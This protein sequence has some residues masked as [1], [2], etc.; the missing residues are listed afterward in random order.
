MGFLDTI[1]GAA[2]YIKDKVV[3]AIKPQHDDDNTP[4][5][6]PDTSRYL[7]VSVP[8]VPIENALLRKMLGRDYMRVLGPGQTRNVG[9]NMMKAAADSMGANNKERRRLR[10][11][12]KRRAAELRA[13]AELNPSVRDSLSGASA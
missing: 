3:N 4:P 5:P 7:H 8:L 2:K 10:T 13:G 9:N 1:K 11:K 12:I 6:A